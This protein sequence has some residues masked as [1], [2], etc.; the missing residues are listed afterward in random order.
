M[1]NQTIFDPTTRQPMPPSALFL[2][3]IYPRAGRSDRGDLCDTARMWLGNHRYFRQLLPRIDQSL[4]A[5]DPFA[6][7][8]QAFAQD[9]A[10]GMNSL[11]G[12]LEGHHGVEDEYYFPEFRRAEPR[13]GAGFDVL[14]ADHKFIHAALETLAQTGTALVREFAAPVPTPGATRGHLRDDLR[15]ALAT[16]EASLLRHLDDEEDLVIPFLLNRSGADRLAA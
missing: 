2:A 12:G 9:L 7:E 4:A 11:L 15:G 8:G 5:H 6:M 16:F 1:T 14:D 10:R 13:L 3:Q